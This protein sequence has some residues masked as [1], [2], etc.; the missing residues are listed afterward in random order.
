MIYINI[1]NNY[2]NQINKKLLDFKE[3]INNKD[4]NNTNTN[5]NNTNANTNNTNTNTNNTNNN[6]HQPSDIQPS[7]SKYINYN[8]DINKN[9]IDNRED[10]EKP[11]FLVDENYEKLIN[12]LI[13]PTRTNPL[14]RTKYIIPINI[15]TRGEVKNYQQIGLLTNEQQILP[16]F[17]KP[18]YPGSSKWSYYTTTDKYQMIKL[19]IESK[20]KNCIKEYG[21]D[22]LYEN[23]AVVVPAY[24]KTYKITIYELDTLNYLPYVI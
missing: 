3:E 4:S 1:N 14:N 21:C 16:L 18:T 12:P 23:D 7:S 22:E 9:I 13:P 19:P 6:S 10:L 17:G 20:N 8:I 5:T 24:N 2:Q 11:L 15:S